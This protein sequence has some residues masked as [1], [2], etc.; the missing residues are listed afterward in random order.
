MTLFDI[1]CYIN[2]TR[3]I[4]AFPSVLITEHRQLNATSIAWKS[5]YNK[6]LLVGK[7]F[8]GEIDFVQKIVR[9]MMLEW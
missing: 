2:P 3:N 7:V 9:L 5:S 6:N 1:Y 8:T 4:G